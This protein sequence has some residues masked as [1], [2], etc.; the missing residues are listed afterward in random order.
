[1]SAD[2]IYTITT[3]S[4]SAIVI[5]MSYMHFTLKFWMMEKH[6]LHKEEPHFAVY[7]LDLRIAGN[8]PLVQ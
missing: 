8:L 6:S 2:Q 3:T 7:N 5:V 1:M 4:K